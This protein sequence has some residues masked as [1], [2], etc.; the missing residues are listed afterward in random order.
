MGT[1]VDVRNCD[2]KDPT[3]VVSAITSL[4]FNEV[5]GDL[6]V[7]FS[8]GNTYRYYGVTAELYSLFAASPSRG[9]FFV[10]H[11]R[12]QFPYRRERKLALPE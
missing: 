9:E 10:T 2:A 11:I 12:D 1:D 8:S 7:T 5:T 4:I 3:A 6:D